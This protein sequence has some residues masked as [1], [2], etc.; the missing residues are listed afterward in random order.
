MVSL[1]GRQRGGR[2]GGTDVFVGSLDE[3]LDGALETLGEGDLNVW[4]GVLEGGVECWNDAS[5]YLI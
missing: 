1:G 5:V 3:L 2:E 4:V